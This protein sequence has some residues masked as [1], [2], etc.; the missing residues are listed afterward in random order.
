MLNAQKDPLIQNNIFNSN[1]NGILAEDIATAENSALVTSNGVLRTNHVEG[2]SG[3]GINDLTITTAFNAYIGNFA[4]AN[5]TNYSPLPTGTPIV[6][7]VVG[8]SL[9]STHGFVLDNYAITS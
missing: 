9:P 6:T 8:T 5:G 1:D 7:W 4:R 2:N 3:F